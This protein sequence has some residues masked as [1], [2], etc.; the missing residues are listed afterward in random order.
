MLFTLQDRYTGAH[1][2][3]LKCKTHPLHRADQVAVCEM[4]AHF[5]LFKLLPGIGRNCCT[6]DPEGPKHAQWVM[7][8]VSGRYSGNLR[9]GLFFSFQEMFTDLSN[10]AP[11]VTV[12]QHELMVVDEWCADGR[13]LRISANSDCHQ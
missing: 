3:V 12:L 11:Y 8:H 13:R 7:G 9:A 4:S 10:M 1:W 2:V 6:H 5:S